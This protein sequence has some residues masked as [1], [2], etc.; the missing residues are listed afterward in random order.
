MFTFSAK[1]ACNCV[2]LN[3]YRTDIYSAAALNIGP[4]FLSFASLTVSRLL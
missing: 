3:I 4:L 1:K 2:G